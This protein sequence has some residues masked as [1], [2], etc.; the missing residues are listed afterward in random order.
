MQ[1][2]LQLTANK[3]RLG[4]ALAQHAGRPNDAV[5]R[6]THLQA[7]AAGL[8]QRLRQRVL[9]EASYVQENL[10]QIEA[11][12]PLG[13]FICAVESKHIE[14]DL[15]SSQLS[16][17]AFAGSGSLDNLLDKYY[18]H[19]NSLADLYNEGRELLRSEDVPM[20]S[21]DTRRLLDAL[22]QEISY[23]NSAF[24]TVPRWSFYVLVLI[25]MVVIA[26]A[27]FFLW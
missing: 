27:W 15:A 24:G 12:N 18:E 17:M 19:L 25:L 7:R 10:P 14:L 9:V 22:H 8:A 21:D 5:S 2:H 20:L 3:Y 4:L 6:L 11:E 26:T 16:A 13:Y 1:Q 23:L